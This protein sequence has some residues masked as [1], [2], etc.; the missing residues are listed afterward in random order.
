MELIGSPYLRLRKKSIMTEY[1]RLRHL[2]L[3]DLSCLERT[4]ENK[5]YMNLCIYII[6]TWSVP[7]RIWYHL[8][9]IILIWIV[10]WNWL[11]ALLVDKMYDWSDPYDWSIRFQP[12][13]TSFLI[14]FFN[15]IDQNVIF[16]AYWYKTSVS[17]I[18]VYHSVTMDLICSYKG[19]WWICVFI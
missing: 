13:L 19:N 14:H 16:V 1:S 3:S 7:V 8:V 12:Y 18:S 4:L 10:Q 5:K 15:G 17:V 11:K 2:W 6:V 9:T